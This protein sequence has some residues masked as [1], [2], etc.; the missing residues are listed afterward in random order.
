MAKDPYIWSPT[1]KSEST[2]SVM[3]IKVGLSR[4]SVI[5]AFQKARIH[6][7]VLKYLETFERCSPEIR[8]QLAKDLHEAGIGLIG[9]RN[10]FHAYLREPEGL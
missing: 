1:I 5:R 7:T 2:L 3:T 4:W 8:D 9:E 10:D 6:S